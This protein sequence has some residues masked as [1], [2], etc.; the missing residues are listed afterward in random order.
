MLADGIKASTATTGTGTVTLT[1][2]SGFALFS[3]AFAVND[4]VDYGISDG[5]SW[6][7]GFGTV[8]AN[9]TLART[10]VKATIVAGTYTKNPGTGLTLSGS[11]TV[12]CTAHAD[13]VWPND[14]PTGSIGMFAASTAP[15]GWLLCDGTAVSRTT[16][17]ALFA[18]IS[19]AFGAGDGSTTFNLP[20][21]LGRVPVGSGAGS[22]LTSRTLGVKSGE[23]THVLTTA[24]MPGHTHNELLGGQATFLGSSGTSVQFGAALSG[25]IT[26]E[27]TGST[28]GGAAHN[29]MQPFQVVTFIIKT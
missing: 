21:L 12:F 22:G 27:T 9:D 13:T 11:S 23:E 4:V 2:I 20:D 14:T 16:Y 1:A 7:W 28:G 3:A 24:E 26:P 18:A 15:T 29:N 19:T 10:T 5:T 17:A 8:G 25:D 6:E